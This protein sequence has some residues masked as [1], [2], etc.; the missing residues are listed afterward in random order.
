MGKLSHIIIVVQI[1]SNFHQGHIVKYFAVYD[2]RWI[3]A[4]SFLL[5]IVWKGTPLIILTCIQI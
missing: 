5:H 4:H 3:Y 2:K 1:H